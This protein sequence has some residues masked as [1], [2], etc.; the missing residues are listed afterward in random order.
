M[1]TAPI[2]TIARPPPR[3]SSR[4]ARLSP[5]PFRNLTFLREEELHFLFLP[6]CQPCHSCQPIV[7]CGRSSR[8]AQ[9]SFEFLLPQGNPS[10][11]FPRQPPSSPFPPR[12]LFCPIGSNSRTRPAQAPPMNAARYF[13]R[14]EDNEPPAPRQRAPSAA[15]TPN[16][17][18]A[19]PTISVWPAPSMNLPVRCDS[20]S[21]AR[22]VGR[23]SLLNCVETSSARP[24]SLGA[25]QP[26]DFGET[27]R[28]SRL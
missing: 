28:S 15:S 17:S 3:R 2:V 18:S 1:T 4:S 14:R 6:L 11:P 25:R 16:A 13:I 19:D 12:A 8:M 26:L 27:P 7:R 20:W 24:L 9:V 23:P 21:P 10:V 5:A 22:A